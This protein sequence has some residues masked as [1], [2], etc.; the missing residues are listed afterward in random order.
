MN[1]F[2]VCLMMQYLRSIVRSVIAESKVHAYSILNF[3]RCCQIYL[4]DLTPHRSGSDSIALVPSI[5]E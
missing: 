3:S 2:V 1:I 5:L 4:Y